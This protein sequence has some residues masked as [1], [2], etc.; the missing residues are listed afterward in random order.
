MMAFVNGPVEKSIWFNIAFVAFLFGCLEAHAYQSLKN[1][2][3]NTITEGSVTDGFY[4]PDDVLGYRPANDR[5]VH[6]RKRKG[7]EVVYD[8][9][10]S[11]NS[12]GLRQ[13]PGLS[14][15]LNGQ[16]MLFFGGSYTFGEGVNDKQ[17]MPSRVQQASS[18]QVYNFGFSGYG[19]HQM[20]AA[21]E[22][23]HAH[24]LQSC[25]PTVA[26]YQALQEHILRA[27]GYTSWD[28]H[29]PRYSIQSG[30]RL[31]YAGH[32]DDGWGS[33]L[34][35]RATQQMA[36]SYIY[37]KFFAGAHAIG[38]QDVNRFLAIIEQSKYSLQQRYP[39][40]EFYVLY[41][42]DPDNQL[43]QTILDGLH[44][45][46]IHTFLISDILLDYKV[47]KGQYQISQYEKHPGP[48]VHLDI[49]SYLLTHI[50]H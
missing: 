9:S 26:V 47:N 17:T 33:W 29:G 41:W 34:Q 42:D 35:T 31:S 7:D 30:G 8:V 18:Y 44:Q 38:E 3:Y 19:P 43:N 37:K 16:C 22:R 12:K 24:N 36:K 5:T 4:V 21:I 28:K 49:A 48:Q 27:G 14:G 6:A 13:S 10:Y 15:R 2:P 45:R 20:L 1:S 40:L 11:I 39:G 25:Q 46:H 32:F 50:R 23:G